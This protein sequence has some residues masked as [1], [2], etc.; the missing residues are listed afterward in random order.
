MD[1]RSPDL[2]VLVRL[3]R[4]LQAC[5]FPGGLALPSRQQP[6]LPQHAPNARG[7]HRHHVG[8]RH[9]KCQS[10]ITFP[11]MLVMESDDR[12]LLPASQP[13][14]PG[15]PTVVF[16]DPTVALPPVIELAGPHSQPIDASSDAD[17]GLLRPAPDEIYDQIP[18]VVRHPDLGQSSP[19]PFL[20][21]CAQP[22]IRLTPRP[23]SGS[24]FP[25]N[26]CVVVRR[27]D[28]GGPCP[29]RQQSRSRRTLSASGR[30]PS[31]AAPVRH[32][33]PIPAPYPTSAVSGWKPSPPT[34]NA[35]VLFACVLSV[36]VIL[37]EERSFQF[38][39]RQHKSE[40]D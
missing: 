1:I 2:P 39:L 10:P 5:S 15:N 18:H 23:W 11:G 22:S 14:T 28:A 3:R 16:I 35:S 6:G 4:V 34:C 38:Q 17:L 24:S 27:E 12:L 40:L 33:D 25:G 32:R 13:K 9:H 26:R 29:G 31:A 37:T 19:R 8:I 20:R 36:I 30:I 21:R 7:T